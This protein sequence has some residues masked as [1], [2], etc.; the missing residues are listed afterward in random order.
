MNHISMG[1]GTPMRP[2]PIDAYLFS[3]IYEDD[4]STQPGNFERHWGIFTYDGLPKYQL[5]LG[6]TKTGAFVRAQNVEVSRQEMV[7]P[8]ASG[9][10]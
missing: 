7:C 2:G 5:N 8:Q 6:M 1:Q 4:K 9:Q 3:L 10:P